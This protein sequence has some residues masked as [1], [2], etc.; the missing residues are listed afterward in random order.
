MSPELSTIVSILFLVLGAAAVWTMMMRLGRQSTSRAFLIIH[1]VAGWSFALVFLVMTAVMTERMTRHWEPLSALNTVHGTLA[2]AL[3]LLLTLKLVIARFFPGLAK[4]LVLIGF[5]TF[6]LAFTLV[7][8]SAGYYLVL[9]IRKI[10]Y[11]SHNDLSNTELDA[12]R[13]KQFLIV[14]CATCHVVKDILSNNNTPEEWER[15]V[16]RM[17][18]LA[19]PQ[20]TP[21]EARQIIYFL[22]TEY[23]PHAGESVRRSA[24]P[25]R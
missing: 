9:K 19:A 8:I 3:L 10:P 23:G 22:A 25:V 16:N 6:L 24:V 15:I 13:G 14:K 18:K 12:Q 7:G 21:G 2:V 20:I 5:S 4:H 1:R 11:I 17:V